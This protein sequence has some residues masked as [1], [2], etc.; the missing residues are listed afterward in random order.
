MHGSKTANVAPGNLKTQ[1]FALKQGLN[2]CR[3]FALWRSTSKK[4]I[5]VEL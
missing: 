4:D 5:V 2:D 3:V 1:S